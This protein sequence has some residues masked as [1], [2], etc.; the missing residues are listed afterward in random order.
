MVKFNTN[1]VY[2][3]ALELSP[4]KNYSIEFVFNISYFTIRP[5]KHHV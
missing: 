2:T 3:E 4:A 1:T 5:I